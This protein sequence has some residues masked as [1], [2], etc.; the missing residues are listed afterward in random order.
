MIWTTKQCKSDWAWVSQAEQEVSLLLL[1]LPTP[2]SLN[3]PWR[4][5]NYERKHG[6]GLSK[7]TKNEFY[8]T[9]FAYHSD[10]KATMP[11]QRFLQP[12]IGGY[13]LVEKRQRQRMAFC[14]VKYPGL[15]Q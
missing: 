7:I 4:M 12:K 15:V 11:G 9:C 10:G 13:A 1:K 3:Q 2:L 8:T 5:K 6:G 14:T